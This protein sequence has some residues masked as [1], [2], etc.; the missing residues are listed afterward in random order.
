[1]G[2]TYTSKD[3]RKDIKYKKHCRPRADRTLF[4]GREKKDNI[5]K[6]KDVSNLN[7]NRKGKLI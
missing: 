4:T 6:L 3:L 2:Y 7:K 1:M 5:L